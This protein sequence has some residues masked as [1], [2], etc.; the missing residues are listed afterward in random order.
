M[1]EQT[2]P[3]LMPDEY[4]IILLGDISVGKTTFFLRIK[5]GDYM[6]TATLTTSV[7]YLPF[8]VSVGSGENRTDVK[9]LQC[10]FPLWVCVCM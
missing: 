9:V 6:D 7:E 4:K 1:A 5:V 3:A 2:S 10:N 8:V